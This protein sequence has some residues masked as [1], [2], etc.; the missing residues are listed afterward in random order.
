MKEVERWWRDDS[1][2]LDLR[3]THPPRAETRTAEAKKE[4]TSPRE[5][6]PT[7]V[8]DVLLSSGQRAKPWLRDDP[9]S[10]AQHSPPASAA[11]TQPTQARKTAAAAPGSKKLVSG[12]MNPREAVAAP[13]YRGQPAE[14]QGNRSAGLWTA[15]VILALALVAITSYGALVLRQNN[16]S[17]AQLPGMNRLGGRMD[18]TEAKLRD[19]TNNWG[20][21]QDHVAELDRKLGSNLQLAGK[22][23]QTLVDRAK[24]ALNLK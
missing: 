14:P 21:V 19:L 13:I 6:R 22:Q 4:E 3:E 11:A 9:L 12:A 2:I 7:S 1:S 18:A 23:A 17:V 5:N 10:A 15:V 24:R 8:G 16:I 20:N